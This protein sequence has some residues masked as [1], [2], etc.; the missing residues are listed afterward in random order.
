MVHNY[1]I[2]FRQDLNN[3]II[4]NFA[5]NNIH[6]RHKYPGTKARV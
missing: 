2:A 5:V 3:I 6:L 1:N 4:L